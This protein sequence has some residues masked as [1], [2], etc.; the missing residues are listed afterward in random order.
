MRPNDYSQEIESIFGYLCRSAHPEGDGACW[1]SYWTTDQPAIEA[2]VYSG[3]AGISFFLSDYFRLTGASK[4]RQLAR[5]ALSWS[6]HSERNTGVV[7]LGAGGAG[8]G[9]AWLRH[10]E[11]TDDDSAI[12]YARQIAADLMQRPPGVAYEHDPTG[13]VR[14]TELFRGIA[15]QGLFLLRLWDHTK[16][17]EILEYLASGVDW[18]DGGATRNDLGTYWPIYLRRSD[19]EPPES[20]RFTGFCHG[21]AGIGYFL[22]LLFERTGDGKT[23]RLVQEIHDTLQ[24]HRLETEGQIAWK[25]WIEHPDVAP[26]QWCHGTAGIGLFYA[27]AYEAL[28]LQ[29]YLEIAQQAGEATFAWGDFRQSPNQCH[30][31]AGN[32]ELLVELYRMTG[33]RTWLDRAMQFGELAS[34]YRH[35]SPD[36]DLWQGDEPGLYT[37]DFYCGA[38]GIGHFFMRLANP[39]DLGMPVS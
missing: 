11:A 26:C 13:D 27:R 34:N 24:R 38:A 17:D 28:G 9:L 33:T 8:I 1:T 25:Q 37:P 20:G 22:A 12:Q 36:G 35:Q 5:R 14:A 15:G 19:L 32:G 2:G 16:Q 31:L 3:A 4:A 18:L 6:S 21:I 23:R 10:F 29:Q 7:D 30:G 39:E